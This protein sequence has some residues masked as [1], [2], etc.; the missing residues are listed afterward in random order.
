MHVYTS[1]PLQAAAAASSE[2]MK[3]MQGRV[4]LLGAG[5]ALIA[6]L[7]GTQDASADTPPTAIQTMPLAAPATVLGIMNPYL[8][9]AAM[10]T[11][12]AQRFRLSQDIR[13]FAKHVEKVARYGVDLNQRKGLQTKKLQLRVDTRTRGVGGVLKVCYQR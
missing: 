4:S 6:C 13:D 2:G 7:V 1:E 3:I 11:P 5:L 12:G 10:D 8:V 9:A